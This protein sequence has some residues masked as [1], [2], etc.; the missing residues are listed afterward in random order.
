MWPRCPALTVR[1]CSAP[2]P[3]GRLGAGLGRAVMHQVAAATI[4]SSPRTVAAAL[5]SPA[6]AGHSAA[7]ASPG[8]RPPPGPGRPTGGG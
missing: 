3:L 7:E 4:R 8:L 2:R 5:T 6:P 1:G